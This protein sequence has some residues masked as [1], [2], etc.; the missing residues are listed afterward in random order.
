MTSVV[1]MADPPLAASVQQG[2]EG[3]NAAGNGN[4]VTPSIAIAYRYL[5]TYRGT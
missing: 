3:R 2:T 1:A 4:N 5:A